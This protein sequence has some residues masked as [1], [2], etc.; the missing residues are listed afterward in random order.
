MTSPLCPEKGKGAVKVLECKSYG[1]GTG[2]AGSGEEEARGNL[3]A[4]N[5]WKGFQFWVSLISQITTDRT[6]G[7]GFKLCQVQ[8]G[9]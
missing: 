6:R 5:I 4:L 9:C 7:D 8:V 3:L 1:E 2:I